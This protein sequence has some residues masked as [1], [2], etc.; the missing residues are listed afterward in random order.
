MPPREPLNRAT[1]LRGFVSP[2]RWPYPFPRP[3]VRYSIAWI[4]RSLW[5]CPLT[6]ALCYGHSDSDCPS[7]RR[8]LAPRRSHLRAANCFP[9]GRPRS[10]GPQFRA[11]HT[12]P[13]SAARGARLKWQ[14]ANAA[15]FPSFP[16]AVS[17][18][19]GSVSFF[20]RAA[21]TVGSCTEFDLGFSASRGLAATSW[22]NDSC[23]YRAINTIRLG[24]GGRRRRYNL[25]A[26][27][28]QQAAL[29]GF[30]MVVLFF[31]L[32]ASPRVRL[33]TLAQS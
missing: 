10:R 25:C 26:E 20:L 30:S 33:A 12:E 21:S 17:D 3:L 18:V 15:A 16:Q 22:L 9:I 19:L 11:N 29:A 14:V 6:H 2:K 28:I 27:V 8:K 32:F 5:N 23:K 24:G 13:R 7:S 31:S 4:L 1:G